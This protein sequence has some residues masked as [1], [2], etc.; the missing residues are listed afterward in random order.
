QF[1]EWLIADNFVFLGVRHYRVATDGNALE[2]QF[3]TGLGLLRQ[4]ERRVLT[5][6]QQRITITPAIRAFLDEPRLLSLTKSVMRSL[7]HR[8]AYMD[9]VG[10]KQFDAAGAFVGEVRIIGL[11]T[12][13]AYTRSTRAIP[14]VRRKVDA[15]IRRAGFD[16]GGH[17]GKALA[18]VLESY[19]R[20]EL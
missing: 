6:G 8:R 16:A 12:S 18:N 10:I 13:T 15:V 1:L 17:S 11:F 19:P 14:Y 5:L 20:D 7:V 9:Y 4:R 2:A 3:E